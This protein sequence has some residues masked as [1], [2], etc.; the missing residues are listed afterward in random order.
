MTPDEMS[1]LNSPRYGVTAFSILPSKGL[2]ALLEVTAARGLCASAEARAAR[3]PGVARF[4]GPRHVL[5]PICFSESARY[6]LASS[7][8]GRS[9]PTLLATAVPITEKERNS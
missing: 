5:V 2:N 6:P 1:Y 9:R 4:I 7:E 8:V 3:G